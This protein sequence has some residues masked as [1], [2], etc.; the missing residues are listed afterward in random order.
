MAGA[1]TAPMTANNAREE[2]ADQEPPSQPINA[3]VLQMRRDGPIREFEEW[4]TETHPRLVASLVLLCGKTHEAAEAADEAFTRAL[5]RW[6]RVSRMESPS[7]WVYRVA[8]RVLYRRARRAA[9]E[10]RLLARES[11]DTT[12]PPPAG[13]I[14]DAVRRLPKRQR[15]AVVLY[16]VADLTE[17]EIADVL[18]VNRSTVGSALADARRTLSA[19]VA[20]PWSREEEPHGRDGSVQSSVPRLR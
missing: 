6:S 20:D 2:C 5:A 12:V 14:W 13:E 7:G 1:A 16:Y 18:G 15:T 8:T 11:T 3:N 4:Y 17:S 10:R 19:F 9:I